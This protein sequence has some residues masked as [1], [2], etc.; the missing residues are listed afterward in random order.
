MPGYL[1]HAALARHFSDQ[2][3]IGNSDSDIL[4]KEIANAANFW[5]HAL[6]GTILKKGDQHE[7]ISES[8]DCFCRDTQFCHQPPCHGDDDQGW[9]RGR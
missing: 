4:N 1:I 7:E 2:L 3:D 5:L 6:K 8:F 9:S